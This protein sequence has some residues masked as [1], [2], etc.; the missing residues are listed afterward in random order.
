[1]IHHGHCVDVL[2]AMAPNS[3]HCVVTSPP[4][5]SLRDYGVPPSIW[6]GDASC[7][8]VWRSAGTKEGYGAKKKWQHSMTNVVATNGRGEPRAGDKRARTRDDGGWT[9]IEQGKFCAK[10][11]AWFGCLGLEP[12]PDLYVEHIT[13]IFAEVRRVLRTDGTCW[14]N[15]GDCYVAG[16][17]GGD[18]GGSST[19]Q[20]G[21]RHQEESKIAGKRIAARTSFRRD[22]QPTGDVQHKAAP[23]LKPKDLCMIPARV[24]L[25]LQADGWYLRSDIVW[26]KSNPMPESAHDRPTKSHEYV[27]LLTKAESYFYDAHAVREGTT[28]TSHSRGTGLNPKAKNSLAGDRRRTGLNNRC[29][30]NA[31]FAVSV[32]GTV[33]TRNLRSVWTLPTAPFSGYHFA[34]FPPGLVE[35]CILAGTS[36]HGC[37]SAC[38]APYYREV[39]RGAELRAQKIAN[40]CNKDGEYHGTARKDYAAAGAQDPSAVKARI[41][42]GMR[43]RITTGWRPSCRCRNA[44]VKPSIVL[45]IFSGM[46]TTGLVCDRTGRDFLGIELNPAFVKMGNR[47]RRGAEASA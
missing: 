34:T 35:P 1:V 8:H 47:R 3:V 39:T 36:A 6:G 21:T 23:G 14:L 37:C 11:G 46:A 30:Q 13:S 42:R 44:S 24:A 40:G 15:L 31:S 33:T 38:G 2:R 16:G 43:E 22:R 19:L 10:C 32:S 18:T 5:W 4:Y 7:R 17:R 26:A 27:F 9:Q 25:A 41:L 20:G 29:K 12:T 45:D 28:G